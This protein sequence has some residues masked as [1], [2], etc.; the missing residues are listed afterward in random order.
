MAEVRALGVG[1]SVDD[2]GTGYSSLAYLSRLPV[3]V[4]KLD[5]TFIEG[6][7]HRSYDE[8][9][10]RAVRAIAGALQ[11]DVVAEGVETPAQRDALRALGV[12]TAQG[13]LWGAAVDPES[14]VAS[15]GRARSLEAG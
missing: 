13:W 5:R 12:P 10:V 7:G 4:V 2:F 8:A 15:F 1:L 9:I 14:F 3:T 6:L 11:L